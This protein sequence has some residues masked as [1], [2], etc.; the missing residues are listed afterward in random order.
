VH[1]TILV[2]SAGRRVALLRCFRADAQ[3]LGVELRVLAADHDPGKSA[4]CQAADACFPV[5]MCRD[6][7]FIPAMLEL[8]R[9]EGVGLLIPTI[10]TELSVLAEH[11]EAFAAIGTRVA[12]SS[13]EVVAIAREKAWTARVLAAAGVM[14]PRTASL[15]ELLRNPGDW[16]WPVVL[17]PN[18]GSSSVGLQVVCSPEEALRLGVGRDDLLT[19]E[20]WV[21]REYT[22]NVFFDTSGHLRCAVPHWRIETHGGE[23]S[24]ARTERV[25]VLEEAAVKIAAALPGARAVLCYQAIV[26]ADGRAG[27]FELNARFGGGYPLA[28]R[29]GARFSQ[30]LLE[31]A[32]DLPCSA[33]NNWREGVT[34]LRYDDAFFIGD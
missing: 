13:P 12:V 25:P 34:M 4:A 8:C 19:Q 27:V 11:F 22:V 6:V 15:A 31:E 1:L 3:K 33:N 18:S 26:T 10:D 30:W 14:V 5:P 9:R 32:L 17:K 16:R 21:G 28:H 24:K 29:A 23:V 7:G 2:S 20:R